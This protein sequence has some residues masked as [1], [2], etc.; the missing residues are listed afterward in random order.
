MGVLEIS[1]FSF[2]FSFLIHLATSK[3]MMLPWVTLNKI[4]NISDTSLMTIRKINLVN[5]YRLLWRKFW[6]KLSAYVGELRSRY[7]LLQYN[8]FNFK[9]EFILEE[10][11]I[12]TKILC[13]F[14]NT[15]YQMRS[16]LVELM[17][18][19]MSMKQTQLSMW[20]ETNIHVVNCI[21]H[22]LYQKTFLSFNGNKNKLVDFIVNNWM[23]NA[24]F[25]GDKT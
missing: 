18:L 22:K 13:V 5:W 14:W 23:S 4:R 21:F 24:I 20:K 15:F 2:L 3:S 1:F 17:L 16:N 8:F 9:K 7:R 19:L 10:S 12:S 25:V 6:K 11:L